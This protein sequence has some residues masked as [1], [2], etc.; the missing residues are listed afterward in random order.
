[1]QIL[2]HHPNVEF[3]SFNPK[4]RNLEWINDEQDYEKW[5]KGMTGYPLWMQE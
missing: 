1:M 5:Q 3:E 4:Y 2:Y